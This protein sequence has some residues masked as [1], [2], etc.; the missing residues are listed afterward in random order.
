MKLSVCAAEARK[1]AREQIETAASRKLTDV[2]AEVQA[3]D[4]AATEAKAQVSTLL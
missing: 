4:D 2:N 3:L 1:Q